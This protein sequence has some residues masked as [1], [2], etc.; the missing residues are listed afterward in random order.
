MVVGLVEVAAGAG[1][2]ITVVRWDICRGSV[3][4]REEEEVATEQQ[5]M[6]A[7]FKGQAATKIASQEDAVARDPLEPLTARVAEVI[8]YYWVLPGL[9]TTIFSSL[10]HYVGNCHGLAPAPAAR[11]NRNRAPFCPNGCATTHIN[12]HRCKM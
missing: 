3:Q 11:Q 7:A 2:V 9:D 10:V 5:A 4:S 6:E 8:M 1:P 12:I